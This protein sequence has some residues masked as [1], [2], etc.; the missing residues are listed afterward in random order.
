[1]LKSQCRNETAITICSYS[2]SSRGK[3]L[4]WMILI[5]EEKLGVTAL[6]LLVQPFLVYVDIRLL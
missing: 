3:E 4:M 6:L 1:M 5:K 2:D